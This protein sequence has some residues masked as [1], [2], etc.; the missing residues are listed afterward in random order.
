MF[1]HSDKKEKKNRRDG[2]KTKKT[3]KKTKKEPPKKRITRINNTTGISCN[4]N[5]CIIYIYGKNTL[6]FY[7]A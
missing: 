4:R 7:N 1:K 3:E 6:L 5:I 2:G